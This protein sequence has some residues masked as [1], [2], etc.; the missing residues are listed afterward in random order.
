MIVVM[1]LMKANFV[2]LNTRPVQLKS[3]HVKTLNVSEINIDAMV[4]FFIFLKSQVNY[5]LI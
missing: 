1:V 5:L 2:T 4:S 3:L